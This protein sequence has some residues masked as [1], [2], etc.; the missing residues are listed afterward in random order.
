MKYILRK[1]F[2]FEA[3]HFLPL[4]D[5]EHQCKR[6]H[7]HSYRVVVEFMSEQLEDGMVVDFKAIDKVC[8]GTWVAI[9]DHRV[10]NE[11]CCENP[12]AENIAAEIATI[13]AHECRMMWYRPTN[14]SGFA[15][16]YLGRERKIYLRAVE[17]RETEKTMCRLEVDKLL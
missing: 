9:Y 16:P 5:N 2:K 4:V 8:K 13:T 6:M 14:D 1:E 7:G 11:V 17:V 12:T 10:L 15:Q 3:A